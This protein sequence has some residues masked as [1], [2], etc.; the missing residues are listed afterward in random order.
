M[1]VI[2]QTNYFTVSPILRSQNIRIGTL[3][4]FYPTNEGLL[5]I[6]VNHGQKVCLRL[7]HP[8]DNTRFLDLESCIGTMLHEMCHNK[9]G[10]HDEKFFSYLKVLNAEFDT[11]M[12]NGYTGE[13]FNS[14][15]HR[16]GIGTTDSSFRT[17]RKKAL[18]SAVKRQKYNGLV[19]TTTRLGG[20][21][22]AQLSPKQLMLLAAERRRETANRR[23][24]SNDMIIL[25]RGNMDHK[26]MVELGL[27]DDLIEIDEN[28]FI[29]GSSH[30]E[31]KKM[32]PKE[33]ENAHINI[34]ELSDDDENNDIETPDRKKIKVK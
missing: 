33:N 19:G 13:G 25:N 28:Q 32:K 10:P 15:G 1:Y 31:T 11:L 26:M 6:N 17:T 24:T 27:E 30:H 5:G 2:S 3:S 22:C 23:S 21:R 16:L 34:I 7:R 12:T 29:K 4:E 14:E 9:H 8:K 18:A 20:S